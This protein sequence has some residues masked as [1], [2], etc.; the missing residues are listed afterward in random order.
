MNLLLPLAAAERDA[1]GRLRFPGRRLH[2]KITHVFSYSLILPGYQTETPAI[3]YNSLERMLFH[4]F[5]LMKNLQKIPLFRF[6]RNIR[7]SEI[8]HNFGDFATLVVLGSITGDLP[9]LLVQRY[10]TNL[11]KAKQ[12]DHKSVKRIIIEFLLDLFGMAVSNDFLK[13]GV[14]VEHA[15]FVSAPG[16]KK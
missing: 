9:T 16:L 12:A 15:P 6:Y 2:Q 11:P 4:P 13:R 8:I 1:E 10:D 3:L 14:G 7:L 5:C